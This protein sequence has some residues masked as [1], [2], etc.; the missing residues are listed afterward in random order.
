LTAFDFNNC[1]DVHPTSPPHPATTSSTNAG[2]NVRVNTLNRSGFDAVLISWL[3]GC[4]EGDCCYGMSI[5]IHGSSS[6]VEVS[7]E[8]LDRER[9]V[10]EVA[11]GAR[12][13]RSAIER[14]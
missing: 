2:G 12:S 9:T 3:N 6:V 13:A 5:E 8:V 11:A 14:F 10:T 7:K 4:G 1:V